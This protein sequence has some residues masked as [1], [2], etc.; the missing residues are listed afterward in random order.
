[1]RTQ[2]P[3]PLR[4]LRR[5]AQVTG[6]VVVSKFDNQVDFA[7]ELTSR[8]VNIIPLAYINRLLDGVN[9]LLQA[10]GVYPASLR[11]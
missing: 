2:S 6:G 11:V 1:M 3:R 4:Q 7:C 10:I 9:E 5:R 8:I